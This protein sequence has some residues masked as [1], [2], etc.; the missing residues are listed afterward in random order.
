MEI[1]IRRTAPD[2][3]RAAA[4]ATRIALLDGPPDDEAW[5]KQ[6]VR[7]KTLR[8]FSAWE[9][10][11]CVG[12][13][14]SFDVDTTVPGGNR[15]PTIAVT[16][17]GVLPTHVG[18]GVFRR[19]VDAL[20][21][22]ATADGKVLSSL[23]ASEA[24]I[25]GHFGYGMAGDALTATIDARRALPLRGAADGS[26]E[27]VPAA[28]VQAT[29]RPLY[30]QA[31]SRPG[32]ITRPDWVWDRYFENVTGH[33]PENV[34]LHRSVDGTPD[35]YIH[36]ELKWAEDIFGDDHGTGTVH[37]VWASDP[38]VEIA[39]W[40]FVLS[41]PL[42]KRLSI[43]ELAADSVLFHSV[44]DYRAIRVN[45]RWDEQWLRLLDVEAALVAR[46]WGD[47]PPV[48]VEVTGAGRW[49]IGGGKVEATEADAELSTDVDGLSAAYLGST[50]WWDLTATS[51]ATAADGGAVRRADAVFANRPLAFCGT[52]F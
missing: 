18:R 34:L 14:A 35:G 23:R 5:E 7:W 20:H 8:S 28:D 47:A 15:L 46:A 27:L 10:D 12:H 39:L 9:G 44:N 33:T 4:T 22:D 31:D 11:A 37:E 19:L 43:D 52:F 24:T 50:S 21:D 41:T 45:M 25:Y 40:Q 30:D 3:L 38:S 26:F 1:E 13:V 17:A 49:R 32:H 48:V 16:S 51:R 36:Y 29:V 2:E 42:V 6:Q